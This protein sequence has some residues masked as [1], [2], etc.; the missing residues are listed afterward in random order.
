[1]G[2]A[3][4]HDVLGSPRFEP[5]GVLGEGG[6]GIVYEVRVRSGVPV[7]DGGRIALKVL[8]TE[9]GP[10]ERELRRFLV[11]AERMRRVAH[12]GLVHL[13]EAGMLPDGRPYLAMPML[14]GETLASRLRRGRLPIDLAVRFFGTLAR[15][16]HALHQAGMVHRDVKPENIMLVGSGDAARPVLLDFGIARDIE[17]TGGS[18]T[19]AEGRVRGTPAYMAP[20]RFFGTGASVQSDVYE[21][22]V[23][24]YM[25]LV[26]K[27][28][29]GSERNATDRLNPTNPR[30]VCADVSGSLART[31]LRAL[32]T[33]AE[34]RP[35]SA[36][37][38]ACEVE[39]CAFDSGPPSRP[40]ADIAVEE[41]VVALPDPH[42]VTAPVA[43]APQRS[44]RAPL[45]ALGL[46][47]CVTAAAVL[48]LRSSQST[49]ALVPTPE[50]GAV[51]LAT[52]VP[53]ATSTVPVATL[54]SSLASAVAPEP[55]PSVSVAMPARAG[56]LPRTKSIAPATRTGALPTGTAHAEK[57]E[58]FFEDRR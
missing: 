4:P 20:E 24:L 49:R 5:L 13:L 44:Q 27:L 39:A 36:E 25:M 53:P 56:A 16:V 22:A 54:T 57:D 30:D 31:I 45:V 58:R 46:V 7:G 14:D 19:T 41:P 6:S 9:L 32:S 47:A 37:E 48:A 35:K 28:P 1:M 34:V 10:S 23:V 21:L 29:W 12:E 15:A 18:T 11:E 26:G 51:V 50:S 2:L 52:S 42:A 43:A 3:V 33:R 55:L 40:T 17:D 38:L 8:R